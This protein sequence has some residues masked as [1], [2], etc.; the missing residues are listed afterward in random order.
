MGKDE[1]TSGWVED[2]KKVEREPERERE[3]R[4]E[5]YMTR[6]RVDSGL[7]VMDVKVEKVGFRP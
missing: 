3:R 2:G 1:R 4:K 7:G 5:R 6:P